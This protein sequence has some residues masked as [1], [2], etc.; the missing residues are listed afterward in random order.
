LGNR[1]NLSENWFGDLTL[2]VTQVGKAT[3]TN[4]ANNNEEDFKAT[5]LTSVSFSVGSRF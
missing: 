2:N 3:L 1:F 5:N 4:F